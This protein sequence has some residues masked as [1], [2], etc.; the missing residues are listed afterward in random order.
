MP[1]EGVTTTPIIIDDSFF[2]HNGCK[3]L[4]LVLNMF[5]GSLPGRDR[6]LLK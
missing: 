2:L 3:I 4:Q 6:E 5:N 1:M